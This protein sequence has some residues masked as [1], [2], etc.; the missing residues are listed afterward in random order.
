M[1]EEGDP[2]LLTDIFGDIRYQGKG[3]FIAGGAGI[4][5]FI[6]IFRQLKK[7]GELGGNSLLFANK[8][9][10][11]II[12]EE[13]LRDLLGKEMT[14]ILSDETSDR[15]LSG[16]ISRELIV[17]QL[18]TPGM[19]VYVCGPPPMMKN[20]IEYLSELKIPEGSIVADEF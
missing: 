12:L 19:N 10:A 7:R 20:V 2:L 14:C 18:T 4:T 15:Y 8:T 6:S 3:L 16:F 1:L 13:E 17:D 9:S 11:D 5:P